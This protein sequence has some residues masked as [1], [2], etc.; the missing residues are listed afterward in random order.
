LL[1]EGQAVLPSLIQ[2]ELHPDRPGV[3]DIPI[4]EE[5]AI[6]R[7]S[8]DGNSGIRQDRENNALVGGQLNLK[9]SLKD[10]CILEPEISLLA[11][12]YQAR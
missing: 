9:M 5:C 1:T 3:D 2:P 12:A 4:S 7:L 6:D 11:A 8:V 10:S